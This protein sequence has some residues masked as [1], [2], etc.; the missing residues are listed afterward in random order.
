MTQD[1]RARAQ[2]IVDSGTS[3]EGASADAT[4]HTRRIA[5]IDQQIDS[6]EIFTNTREVMIAHG[7]DVYRL[8]LTAQNKLIL[9]K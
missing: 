3:T 5:I 9:T 1:S 8:R 4:S 7:K 6:R 2:H